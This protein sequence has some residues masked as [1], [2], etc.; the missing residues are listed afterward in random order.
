MILYI[1][2]TF[3]LFIEDKINDSFQRCVIFMIPFKIKLFLRQVNAYLF[4]KTC[5]KF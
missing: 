2:V 3:I 1:I 4:Y 5:K